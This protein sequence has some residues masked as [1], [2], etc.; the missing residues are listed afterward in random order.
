MQ[1]K[2]ITVT[3]EHFQRALDALGAVSLEVA[4]PEEYQ[5]AMDRM[6]KELADEIDREVLTSLRAL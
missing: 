2:M 5:T 1:P 4:F 6:T 3:P